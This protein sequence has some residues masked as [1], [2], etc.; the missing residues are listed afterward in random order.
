MHLSSLFAI[1]SAIT[2]AMAGWPLTADCNI[3]PKIGD[4]SVGWGSGF[5]GSVAHVRIEKV[6]YAVAL[7]KRVCKAVKLEE[8][9]PGVELFAEPN[10]LRRNPQPVQRRG[11]VGR[12]P[13]GG[14]ELQE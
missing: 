3:Y 13:L 11:L 4:K 2:T 9:P 6:D 5:M 12:E 1:S 10:T 14:L 7:W 8:L